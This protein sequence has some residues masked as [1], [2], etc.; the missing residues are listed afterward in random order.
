MVC[1]AGSGMVS[2]AIVYPFDL[3]KKRLEIRGIEDIRQE[4]GVSRQYKGLFHCLRCVAVEEGWKGLY[5]G[6][7]PSLLK[8]AFMAMS[9]FVIYEQVCELLSSTH[10]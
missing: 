1:G 7:S 9:N 6:L 3:C 8:A 5:K 2:K 10:S 4:F